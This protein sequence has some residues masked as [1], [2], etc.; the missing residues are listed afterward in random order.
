[1]T[2]YFDRP[3]SEQEIIRKAYDFEIHMIEL[4]SSATNPYMDSINKMGL[5]E[6]LEEALEMAYHH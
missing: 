4:D 1:M 3:A 6:A 5:R 2:T